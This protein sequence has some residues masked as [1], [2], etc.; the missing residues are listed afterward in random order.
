MLV[1]EMQN[2]TV[3]TEIGKE[4]RLTPGPDGLHKKVEIGVN[5]YSPQIFI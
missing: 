4:Q 3:V 1:I 5:N 2:N